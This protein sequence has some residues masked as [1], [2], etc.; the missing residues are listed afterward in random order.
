MDA[1]GWIAVYA[2]GLTVLQLLVYRYLV[3][4]GGS[5]TRRVGTPFGDTSVS[6]RSS[7]ASG[8]SSR[9]G[10]GSPDPNQNRTPPGALDAWPREDDGGPQRGDRTR[11]NEPPS[12]DHED[13]RACPHCGAMNEADETFSLCWNCAR[14]L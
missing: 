9:R 3:Q 4:N 6:N 8:Q 2:V 12:A 13:G 5:L 7:G 10:R 1:W 11:A 14:D